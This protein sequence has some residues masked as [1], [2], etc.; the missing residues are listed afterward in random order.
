ML[1]GHDQ[2]PLLQALQGAAQ[3][4]VAE[5]R[6]LRLPLLDAVVD[7]APSVALIGGALEPV[8]DLLEDDG[9]VQADRHR[10]ARQHLQR[11]LIDEEPV[12]R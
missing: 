6:E 5:E 1:G 3:G 12:S 11:W 7:P 2:P 10:E 4:R 8:V 9:L